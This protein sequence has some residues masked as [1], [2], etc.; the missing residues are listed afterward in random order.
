M[1]FKLLSQLSYLFNKSFSNLPTGLPYQFFLLLIV[2]ISLLTYQ[3]S[4]CM[5]LFV[6]LTMCVLNVLVILFFTKFLMYNVNLRVSI[7]IVTLILH[8][9]CLLN[10]R[11]TFLFTLQQ[12]R[13]CC[14]HILTT[15]N[16]L[17]F[18][19]S[20]A[21]TQSSAANE[22]L[23]DQQ[24]KTERDSEDKPL[25]VQLLNYNDLS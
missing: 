17:P 25:F 12:Y 22:V 3:H 15:K 19:L 20:S 2:N 16:Q 14:R 1:G 13:H 10:I 24:V 18:Q 21:Q 6:L 11:Q 9:E 8:M 5:L 7:F 4:C 23:R